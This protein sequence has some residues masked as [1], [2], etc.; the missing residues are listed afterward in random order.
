MFIVDLMILLDNSAPAYSTLVS[1]YAKIRILYVFLKLTLCAAFAQLLP[2]NLVY[3]NCISGRA[4][5][6]IS[7]ERSRIKAPVK[8]SNIG[9][10]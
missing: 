10:A 1:V 6:V 5:C 7:D 9:G 3:G 4:Q 2:S 8:R